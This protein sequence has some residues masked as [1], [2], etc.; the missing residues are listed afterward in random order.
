[1]ALDVTK[2]EGKKADVDFLTTQRTKPKTK[3]ISD[4]KH[5]FD[6]TPTN[7]ADDKYQVEKKA[8]VKPTQIKA[9][10][11]DPKNSDTQILPEVAAGRKISIAYS[12]LEKINE[13]AGN[14]LLNILKLS[15]FSDENGFIDL[16]QSQIAKILKL[17]DT[18]SA[19]RILAEMEKKNLISTN[20][21][22]S[23]YGNKKQY[24]IIFRTNSDLQHHEH[25]RSD[26]ES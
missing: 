19:R 26:V 3:P 17:K 18:R 16:S 25:Q 21:Q 14:M 20:R 2:M 4:V 22:S 9:S 11:T 13:I 8:D 1:M 15:F 23:V 24:Q 5:P 6:N 7:L 12:D 10:A